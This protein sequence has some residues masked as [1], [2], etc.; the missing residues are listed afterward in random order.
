MTTIPEI[1]LAYTEVYKTMR[2][3]MGLPFLVGL[4]IG[5]AAA[6]LHKK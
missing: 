6:W 4:A 2:L 3:E 1:C 5:I